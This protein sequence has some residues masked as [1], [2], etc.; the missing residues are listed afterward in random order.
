MTVRSRLVP[1]LLIALAVAG[2]GGDDGSGDAPVRNVDRPDPPTRPSAEE[3]AAVGRVAGGGESRA[4]LVAPPGEYRFRTEGTQTLEGRSQ[5]LPHE[6]RLIVTP[7]RAAGALRCY[8]VQR[9]YSPRFGD[10]ALAAVAGSSAY[11]SEFVSQG[12]GQRAEFRLS[13]PI[14]LDTNEPSGS[15]TFN[16]T[17][18]AQRGSVSFEGPASGRYRSDFAGRRTITV[19]G[20]DVRAVGVRLTLAMAGGEVKATEESERWVSDDNV[21]VEETVTQTRAI[22]GERFRM[23]YHAELKSLD[24]G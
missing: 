21:L 4:E 3:C 16:G 8:R 9:L 6:T 10:T 2:C 22:A 13:P 5:P 12:G 7:A 20:R 24:P 11:A 1:A 19:A 17:L 18:E 15:G 23:R 14:P